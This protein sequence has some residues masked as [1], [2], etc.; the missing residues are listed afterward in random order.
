MLA[1]FV[2]RGLS[3]RFEAA[4]TVPLR[5]FSR[6]VGDDD[7]DDEG[8]RKKKADDDLGLNLEEIEAPKKKSDGLEDFDEDEP[9]EP[10][11]LYGR[12]K[13]TTKPFRQ[14]APA[15]AR[16]HRYQAIAPKNMAL[17]RRRLLDEF[18]ARSMSFDDPQFVYDDSLRPDMG[19][20]YEKDE[21]DMLANDTEELNFDE[22]EVLD[23]ESKG[24]VRQIIYVDT[25]QKPVT[26]GNIL[27]FRALVCVGNQEGAA[28]YAVGRGGKIHEAIERA[29]LRAMD[30]MVFIDRFDDR[31]LFHEVRG[32]FNSCSLFIRPSKFG[33]GSTVS[34][35][36]GCALYCF[37][38]TDVVSK[39]YGQRNPYTVI[40]ATFDALAKHETAEEVAMKTGHSVYEITNLAKHGKM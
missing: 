32:K 19:L 17:A 27:T 25:V 2:S 22:D 16:K 24:L 13:E 29:T 20:L 38:I 36:V 6:A 31:T 39:C 34:D 3:R 40:K 18:G 10:P 26:Q 30:T 21:L 11:P 8:R 37:G 5:A 4:S 12:W 23:L 35:T 14:L 15:A 7:D 33:M 9:L 28:G 1:R